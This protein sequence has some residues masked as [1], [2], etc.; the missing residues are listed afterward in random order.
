MWNIEKLKKNNFNW[1]KKVCEDYIKRGK[2]KEMTVDEM[3]ALYKKLTG[4]PDESKK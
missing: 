2:L 1:F 4:K 3:K